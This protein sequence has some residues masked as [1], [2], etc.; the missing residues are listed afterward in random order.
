MLRD[1]GDNALRDAYRR[2]ES[3]WCSACGASTRERGIWEV[4]IDHYGEGARSAAD[5]V[6]EAMFRSLRVAEINRLNAGHDLL[7]LSPGVIYSEYPDQDIQALSYADASFDLLLTSDTLEHVP[8][9]RAGLRE[10]RRVLAPRGRHVLTV[11]LRPDLTASRSREGLSPVYH[12]EAPGPLALLR[13][14]SEDMRALH[15]F[16]WDF[17]DAVRD[18]GYAVELHG[19]GIETVICAR[20]E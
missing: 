10:T 12:G 5:L 1:L 14:A 6:Q 9:F 15:D 17:I 20:A 8:D 4:L 7:A 19:E 11:P 18:S 2:R 3:L 16:A 13:R